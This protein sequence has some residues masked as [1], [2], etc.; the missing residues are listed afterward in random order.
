L[1]VASLAIAGSCG[2]GIALA[3]IV[4]HVADERRAFRRA[5]ARA[6]SMSPTPADE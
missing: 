4:L 6:E 2:I 1:A 5:L 3:L